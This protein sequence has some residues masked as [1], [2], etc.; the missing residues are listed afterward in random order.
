MGNMLLFF[1]SEHGI[2]HWN[3]KNFQ[4]VLQLNSV[5]KHPCHSCAEAST[6]TPIETRIRQY[7]IGGFA[8]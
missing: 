6:N 4:R 5:K 3:Y 7:Q 2:S 8:K 1:L